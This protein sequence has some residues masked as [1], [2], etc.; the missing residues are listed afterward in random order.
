MKLLTPSQQ[1]DTKALNQAQEIRR[2]QSIQEAAQRTR[3][4]LSKAN[5][6]FSTTMASFKE[7]WATEEQLHAERVKGM[8]IEVKE[9]EERKRIALIPL[10]IYE[11]QANKILK[12]AQLY[13]VEVANKEHDIDQLRELLE[14][15]LD[16]VGDREQ[17]LRTKEIKLG[18]REKG[19]EEQGRQ[20]TDGIKLLNSQTQEFATR[21]LKSEKELD[22]RKTE[23]ILLERSLDAKNES[24]KRT[25]KALGIWALQLKDQEG[26]LLREKERR[27]SK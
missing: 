13:L 24:N 7:K 8:G 16:D 22:D 23:I 15:K 9:L 11:D 27:V 2:T 20:I 21:K 1:S 6:D 14:N 18:L 25:E 4:D 26:I 19:I 10:K 3:L 12:E 17:K 5:A